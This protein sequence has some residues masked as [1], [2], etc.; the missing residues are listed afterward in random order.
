M[1]NRG[2]KKKKNE[3]IEVLHFKII[4]LSEKSWLDEPENLK[5]ATNTDHL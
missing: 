4:K 3:Y 5:K 2:E 1:G